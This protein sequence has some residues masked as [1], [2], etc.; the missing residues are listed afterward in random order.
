MV[1]NP[2]HDPKTGRFA[3]KSGLNRSNSTITQRGKARVKEHISDAKAYAAAAAGI[4]LAGIGAAAL[5]GVTRPVRA[6]GSIIANKAINAG[7][8]G[9]Q[10]LVAKHGPKI[11]KTI[12]SG[13][14][15]LVNHVKNMKMAGAIQ[16]SNKSSISSVSSS[17]RIAPNRHRPSRN[18]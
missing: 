8:H 10:Q 17:Y 18:H 9:T 12:R 11:T 3:S 7:I 1:G 14:S 5:Q 15:S 6:H 16:H 4:A 2:N 13:G